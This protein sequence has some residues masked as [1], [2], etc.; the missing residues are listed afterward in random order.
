MTSA[1]PSVMRYG[2]AFQIIAFA[3]RGNRP[4]MFN[5]LRIDPP[6]LKHYKKER[7]NGIFVTDIWDDI[8]ELTSGYFAGEEAVR[9]ETG[10]RFHRQQSPIAL[11]LRIIL[12]STRCGDT[13][14]DPFA[15]SGTC[16]AVAAQLY[17]NSINIEVDAENIKCIEKRLTSPRTADS[18]E[19]FFEDYKYT[20]NLAEIWGKSF[21]GNDQEANRNFLAV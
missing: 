1:V 6:L 14:F 20:E 16:A 19:K 7:E 18:V 10:E 8:R 3:T 21:S 4:R 11:L 9:N 13:V 2:K 17:R 12:T 15:G 5:R